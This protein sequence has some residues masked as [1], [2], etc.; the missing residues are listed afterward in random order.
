M[1]NAASRR[2]K[3]SHYL[4]IG[5]QQSPGGGT[6]LRPTD[7]RAA[8]GRKIS[9]G[10]SPTC[11]GVNVAATAIAPRAERRAR[12]TPR[13]VA[14]RRVATP[15]PAKS[16]VES[17][18]CR[19]QRCCRP[20]SP[21]PAC[22]RTSARPSGTG[23]GARHSGEHTARTAARAGKPP[24]APQPGAGEPG[25]QLTFCHSC[26]RTSLCRSRPDAPPPA[27]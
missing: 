7:D 20:R 17:C 9:K 11:C 2:R 19:R 24:S 5:G 3:R 16:S 12:A 6:R 27:R 4:R 18:R 23:R 8:R 10:S 25:F 15:A 14:S 26:E 21:E 13:Q 1:H 22:V